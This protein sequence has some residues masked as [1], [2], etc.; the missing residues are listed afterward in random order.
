MIPTRDLLRLRIACRPVLGIL[1]RG[2]PVRVPPAVCFVL[3]DTRT[4]A[5]LADPY[6]TG[7]RRRQYS[8][9]VGDAYRFVRTDL[10]ERAAADHGGTLA[11]IT[12]LLHDT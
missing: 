12:L 11:V 7:D 8:G 1:I 10:A 5:Y 3:R 2:R 9:H 4:G 6:G